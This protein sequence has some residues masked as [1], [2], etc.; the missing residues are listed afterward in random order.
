[1]RRLASCHGVRHIAN[2]DTQYNITPVNELMFTIGLWA[3]IGV[4]L[5]GGA[6]SERP[7]CIIPDG[8]SDG[9]EIPTVHEPRRG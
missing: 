5:L 1:M 4:Q 8:H 7:V 2:A 6:R 3:I 9:E